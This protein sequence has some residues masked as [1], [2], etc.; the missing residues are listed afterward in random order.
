MTNLIPFKLKVS[1]EDLED[2]NRR[3]NNTRL[4]DQPPIEA[5][6]TGTDITWFKKLLN[7]WKNDYDWK[8]SEEELNTFDQF[9]ININ[10]IDVHFIKSEGKGK[11]NIP[12][13]LL[14]GWPGSVFEFLEI[15]KILNDPNTFG[16]DT[17]FSFTLVAPS[18]PGFG[19]SFKANQKRVG[20]EEIADMLLK[21]LD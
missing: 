4:P 2:L 11:N 20:V 14:H 5:W 19:L 13:L 10:D 17:N 15:I 8:K 6:K 18:L 3:L 7:Y 16:I 21:M 1:N 12:L 9:K